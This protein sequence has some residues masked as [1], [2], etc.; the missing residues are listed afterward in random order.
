MFPDP[1]SLIFRDIIRSNALFFLGIAKK[2]HIS[3]APNFSVEKNMDVVEKSNTTLLSIEQN[4]PNLTH[5]AVVNR[6]YP[7]TASKGRF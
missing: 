6:D 3:Y 2:V 5:L 4:D 7:T 1:R